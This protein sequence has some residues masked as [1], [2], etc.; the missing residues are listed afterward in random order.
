MSKHCFT[1]AEL[2]VPE[3]KLARRYIAIAVCI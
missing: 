1:G 2:K 3:E